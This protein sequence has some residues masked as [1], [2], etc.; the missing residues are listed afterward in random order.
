MGELLVSTLW[1]RDPATGKL[2]KEEKKKK[3]RLDTYRAVS[4]GDDEQPGEIELV[5]V[6]PSMSKSELV[7]NCQWWARRRLPVETQEEPAAYGSAFHELIAA[8]LAGRPFSARRT[9]KNWSTKDFQLDS[10]ELKRHSR[11]ADEYLREWL[12]GDNVWKVDFT[13]RSKLH[14]E[15]SYIW[16]VTSKKARPSKR[17]VLLDGNRHVYKGLKSPDEFPG[18]SDI[19]IDDINT[20]KDAPD[21]IVID[22]KTGEN[23]DL[24]KHS[25][26]LRS[27]MMV[28]AKRTGAK[29]VV[30]GIFHAPR[31]GAPHL[32]TE[33]FERGELSDHANAIR[34]AWRGIGTGALRPGPWCYK[35]GAACPA[36]AVCPIYTSAIEKFDM[37]GSAMTGKRIGAAHETLVR[38]EAWARQ[39]KETIIRPWV[40]AHG[41]AQRPDGELVILRPKTRRNLSMASVTRKYGPVKGA[42]RIAELEKEGVI[43]T[44]T[45]DE[46]IAVRDR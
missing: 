31:E 5:E 18:T 37:K 26:Q 19:A 10:R 45:Y 16:N 13:K 35:A 33:E 23:C 29:R 24:P 6:D 17:P 39:Y 44:V 3:P 28:A 40:R 14:V 43:D 1:K 27:L 8:R 11:L 34:R 15:Q 7:L 20:K 2:V 30:G 46:L 41:P 9:A 32:Y 42:K 36:F 21:L 12:R 22:N 25:A 4:K 38:F